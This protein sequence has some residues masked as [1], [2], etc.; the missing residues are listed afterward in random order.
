L[1]VLW[2][3]ALGS[4]IGGAARYL[5]SRT[6][7]DLGAFTFPTGTLLVNVLGAFALGFVMRYAL[8]T[9]AMSSE[10][11]AFLTTGF[12]GGFTTFSAFSYETATQLED[13]NYKRALTY[14]ALSVLGCLAAM[15][16]GFAGARG[17]SAVLRGR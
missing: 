3:I 8:D 17:V 13:R 12:C 4:A 16:L 10:L 15:Y 1:G 6:V 5:L 2:Y 14:V 9:S 11:R 7:Q